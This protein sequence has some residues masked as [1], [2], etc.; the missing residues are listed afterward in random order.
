MNRRIDQCRISGSRN[1]VSVLNLGEQAFTG[2]FPKSLSQPMPTGPLELVWCAESGLLQL[3]HSFDPVQMYGEN[4][5][6]RSGLNNSMVRHLTEKARYLSRLTAL[7]PGDLVL[8]IG[9]NDATLLKAY[10]TPGL[11]K[12]GIDPTGRKFAE[13]YTKDIQLVPDFFSRDNFVSAMGQAKAKLVTAI[14]MFYDLDDPVGFA[15]QVHECLDDEGVWHLEQSYMP[16][17]LRMTSYD[18]VCH[19]HI[20]YYSLGA[21]QRVLDAADFKILDVVMNAV[22]GGSFA[23][24]AVKKRSVRRSNQPVIQWLLAEERRM[25]LETPRPFRDFEDRVYQ[26]RRALTSL[27]KCLNADGKKILGYGASTKGNVLLQF[28][29]IGPN[30]LPCIADVN[31]DKFG[32][33]TPGTNI[34]IVSE[35][36]A[37]AQKPDYLLVLPWH[38]K[39]HILQ[40]EAEFLAGGGHMIFP[41]PEIEII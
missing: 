2:I 30:D 32:C 1:L 25:G 23:V 18:T 22:N 4:Y 41:L 34:P 11:R 35:A 17:M 26:H 40:R 36:E 8:D 31:P 21:I 29:G 3:G 6:Y 39:P 28:C 20:S 7:Q 33:F 12:L 19:E 27:I 16:S 10:E 37:K 13:F 14:S 38:F 9:S 15:R 5:G 24:S